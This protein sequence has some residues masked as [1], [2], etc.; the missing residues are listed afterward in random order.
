MADNPQQPAA[1]AATAAQSEDR[2][3]LDQIIDDAKISRDQESYDMA[4]EGISGFIREVVKGNRVVDRVDQNVIDAMINDLDARLSSQVNEILHAPEFQKLESSWRSLHSMVQSFNFRENTKLELFNATKDELREDFEDS[5]EVPKSTLY[6]RV[7]K[8]EYGVHGGQP[9]GLMVGNFEMSPG[10][11]DM[12]LLSNLASVAAMSH[13]PFVTNAGP[14]FFG[15]KSF[16]ELDKLKDLSSVFEA[17]Q[18]ARWRAFRES[19]DSRYVGLCVP[20]M[21]MRNVY[22]KDGL[23][24]KSFSFEED[25]IGSNQKYLWGYVSTAFAQR[26]ADSFAKFRWCPNIIG[27]QSGGAVEN[28]PLHTYS[29]GGEMKVKVPTEV[30][31]D[32]RRELELAEQGFISLVFEKRTNRAAFFSANSA[33]IPKSFADTPEGNA[34]KTN[35]TL[36]TRL[37]YVFI[38]TRLAHYLKVMQRLKI[39][40]TTDKSK[41]QRELNE[42]I[43]PYVSIQEN[44]HESKVGSRP[45]ESAKIEV[46]DVDGEP[47]WY[48]CKIAVVPRKKY[49]G[50]SFE[51]SLVGKLDKS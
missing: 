44:L 1:P 17:P 11:E 31:V 25:V 37:P 28:L 47:G 23:K 10:A 2:S 34:A 41:L 15:A 42:W 9:Y 51:L 3:L 7:Y 40:S 48:R 46:E 6:D 50:A 35:Y 30:Q 21:L 12:Q 36:G 19:Q 13:A 4:R 14:E 27:P 38:I 45:L 24:T 16:E 8:Q 18:L 43:R 32:D 20:R 49:E 29:E 22:G 5:I 26:V 39:G 33:Q